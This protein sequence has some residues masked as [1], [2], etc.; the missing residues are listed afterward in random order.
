MKHRMAL[1]SFRLSA[2][3]SS[4]GILAVVVLFDG[5][6]CDSIG[7][8]LSRRDGCNSTASAAG[9][10]L[11]FETL[12]MFMLDGIARLSVQALYLRESTSLY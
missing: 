10:G 11:E 9:V 8:S 5:S 2:G 12:A 4:N 7:P 1:A 6:C 3:V